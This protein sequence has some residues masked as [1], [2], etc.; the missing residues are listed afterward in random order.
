[1]CLKEQT[2]PQADHPGGGRFFILHG[3]QPKIERQGRLHDFSD[4]A[5]SDPGHRRA[6]PPAL[7]NREPLPPPEDQRLQ[8]RGSQPQRP[9]K[10]QAPHG[11]FYH[12]LL[13]GYSRRLETARP[14]SPEPL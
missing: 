6:L 12:G 3:A 2:G 4:H 9:R 10:K 1:M 11:S 8:P 7:E 5:A 13:P 14:Y